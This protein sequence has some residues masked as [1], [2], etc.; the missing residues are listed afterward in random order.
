MLSTT[1]SMVSLLCLSASL[2]T[3]TASGL[4]QFRRGLGPIPARHKKRD[5]NTTVCFPTLDKN[6]DI[7]AIEGDAYSSWVPRAADMGKPY[8]AVDLLPD[9]RKGA[10]QWKLTP[11]PD[12]KVNGTFTLTALSA[13]RNHSR[14]GCAAS[15]ADSASLSGASCTGEDPE[16]IQWSIACQSCDPHNQWAYN[17]LIKSPTKDLCA[18]HV[19]G[20]EDTE[21]LLG[22]CS[23]S[24]GDTFPDG[25]QLSS[26]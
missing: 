6:M 18:T 22:P 26:Y 8:S 17:C 25:W 10:K 1:S 9:D 24:D 11:V 7:Y 14:N 16:P 13:V 15:S 2:A 4:H 5:A 19:S 21:V 20:T 12:A 3:A 23:W